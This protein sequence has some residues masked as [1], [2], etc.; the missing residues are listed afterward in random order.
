MLPCMCQITSIL[1][2]HD[3]GYVCHWS[4]PEVKPLGSP[5]LL[6][7][8][9]YTL[10]VWNEGWLNMIM[11][12]FLY[13]SSKRVDTGTRTQNNNKQKETYKDQTVKEKPNKVV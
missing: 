6:D 2:V 3:D 8:Q 1:Y 11:I 4:R 10:H 12:F 13:Y 5:L 7:T 9:P